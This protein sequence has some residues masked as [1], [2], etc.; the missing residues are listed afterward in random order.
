GCS[1][2]RSS[3][4]APRLECAALRRHSASTRTRSSQSLATTPRRSR[5]STPGASSD[6]AGRTQ[7][8]IC[9]VGSVAPPC[10]AQPRTPSVAAPSPPRIWT[11]G[12]GLLEARRS[13]C[14]RAPASPAPCGSGG[15][16]EG[17]VEAP[18]DDLAPTLPAQYVSGGGSEG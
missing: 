14:L 13:I 16:S 5:D 3:C 9:L 17:A 7:R 4:P 12:S 11:L 15:S 10:D 1:A 6:L 8:P 18:S 2:F